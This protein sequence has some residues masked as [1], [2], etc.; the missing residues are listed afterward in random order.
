MRGCC[1]RDPSPASAGASGAH[2]PLVWSASAIY[3]DPCQLPACPLRA[4]GL[5][6]GASE[7]LRAG[8]RRRTSAQ[9]PARRTRRRAA[10]RARGTRRLVS[11][12]PPTPAT[13]AG[14][15]T[16]PRHRSLPGHPPSRHGRE[17]DVGTGE[18]PGFCSGFD[19][20]RCGA[21]TSPAGGGQP[22]LP[23]TPAGWDHP[24]RDFA[25]SSRW[26]SWI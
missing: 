21:R 2:Q 17:A 19:S 22:L 11:A 12:E 7:S 3:R 4:P 25:W 15:A 1:A 26:P 8:P 16:D 13:A 24:R 20:E 14:P 23:G 18:R 6:H 9:P 5:N 10:E